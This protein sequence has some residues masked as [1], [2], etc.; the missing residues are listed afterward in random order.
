MREREVVPPGAGL[1]IA[2]L[3]LLALGHGSQGGLGAAAALFGAAMCVLVLPGYLLATAA[4][5]AA[6]SSLPERWVIAVGFSLFLAEGA[7]V[8]GLTLHIPLNLMIGA[9]PAAV[10][11]TAGIRLVRRRSRPVPPSAL[12]Q[13]RLARLAIAGWIISAVAAYL[14]GHADLS[15]QLENLFAIGIGDALRTAVRPQDAYFIAG[16]DPVYP[17][18]GLHYALAL[19]TD[20]AGTSTLFAFEKL[21]FI[22]TASALAAV[23]VGV[24]AL[25]GSSEAAFLGLFGSA[26]LMLAGTFGVVPG[27]GFY[28]GQ[29]AA[30]GHPAD[31]AMNVLVPIALSC[32][33]LWLSPQG[34]NRPELLVL[35]VCTALVLSAVHQRELVQYLAYAAGAL[36]L[37]RDRR[38][39]VA[40]AVAMAIPIAA[41]VAYRWWAARYSPG[42]GELLAAT[43]ADLGQQF[44]H[45]SLGNA[46]RPLKKFVIFY[47][48]SLLWGLNGLM[49][50]AS[51]ITVIAYR[52]ALAVRTVGLAMSG[53]L[54]VAS[55]ALLAIPILWMTYDELLYTPV[56]HVIFVLYICWWTSIDAALRSMASEH[57]YLNWRGAAVILPAAAAVA[58]AGMARLLGADAI[59]AEVLAV[60]TAASGL[61]ALLLPAPG[62]SRGGERRLVRIAALL[63]FVLP[64][65]V[66][67]AVPATSF[68]VKLAS[69]D[70]TLTPASTLAAV[71]ALETPRSAG[72]RG[73]CRPRVTR[74]LGRNVES[75]GCAP[76]L[77][78]VEWLRAHLSREAVLLV[79]LLG[80][81]LATGFIATRLAAPV[82]PDR[83]YRNWE[84]AFPRFRQVLEESLDQNGGMPFFAAGETP[85]E[86]YLYARALGATHVLVDPARRGAV[87]KAAGERPDL[88]RVVLD[89]SQWLVVSLAG[90]KRR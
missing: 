80:D 31:I 71:Y 19:V 79:D 26:V 32:L 82:A 40:L 2:S 66:A 52:K 34:R 74:L 9:F 10:A 11:A 45:L 54:L 17:F 39:A 88:F 15:S 57:R 60:A 41:A 44:H 33:L 56:R 76:P 67:T 81:F 30:T 68:A 20:L 13:S 61:F 49:L 7:C 78:I 25:S 4:T 12:G 43:R 36:I 63:A 89:R 37:L 38:R 5:D 64:L 62:T 83:Y 1:S 50:I 73:S 14:V 47:R 22:W 87:L 84:V 6:N 69:G 8:A 90:V 77:Q 48:F 51:A 16:V 21:R 46:F 72:P 86:R 35:C 28:W 23:F 3:A 75:P 85:E 24:R 29:L 58:L 59:P 65:G 70:F 27:V 18:P 42:I 55:F 53:F